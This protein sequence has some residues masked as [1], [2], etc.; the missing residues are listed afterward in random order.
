MSALD[1]YR[2]GDVWAAFR[3]LEAGAKA[4]ADVVLEDVREVAEETGSSTF[5]TPFGKVYSS[6]TEAKVQIL[7]SAAL[8]EWVA[9]NYPTDPDTGSQS[10]IPEHH[11]DLFDERQIDQA[12]NAMA[13]MY[14]RLSKMA[15]RE[16]AL[17][18]LR[19][20]FRPRLVPEK[21]A[22]WVIPHLIERAKIT[23]GS[24]GVPDYVVD[25]E[26]GE[27]WPWATVVPEV[28][29]WNARLSDQSK[30]DAANAVL[31]QLPAVVGM[32]GV[33]AIER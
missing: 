13:S 8:M 23:K 16:S 28:V 4:A 14:P 19:A 21:L 18:V 32:L 5:K 30:M 22:P 17:S 20:A 26:T 1:G 33:K 12:S 25:S 7:V 27:E 29:K 15:A 10:I 9:E 6:T 11:E 3:A 2:P 31:D 24:H